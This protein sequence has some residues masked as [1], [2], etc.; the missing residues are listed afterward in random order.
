MRPL[1]LHMS[2]PEY[3]EYENWILLSALYDEQWAEAGDILRQTALQDGDAPPPLAA[4]R[5]YLIAWL[6]RETGEVE[7]ARAWIDRAQNIEA[8]NAR[9]DNSLI[10]QQTEAFQCAAEGRWDEAEREIEAIETNPDYREMR[11][12]RAIF[13]FNRA[14]CVARWGQPAD[15]PR[16][17]AIARAARDEFAAMGAQGWVDRIDEWSKKMNTEGI[18]AA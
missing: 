15:R 1:A 10:I 8:P 14:K 17:V 6:H 7:A 12:E 2:A 13:Q 9:T 11:A 3:Y 18:G 16:A 4:L 5:H